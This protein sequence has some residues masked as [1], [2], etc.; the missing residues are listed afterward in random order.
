M[1]KKRS[2]KEK[3]LYQLKSIDNGNKKIVFFC[4]VKD[5]L[6]YIYTNTAYFTSVY[7]LWAQI[8]SVDK[9]ATPNKSKQE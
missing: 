7:I 4:E 3:Q 8:L 5:F 9:A 6:E 1:D 2:R